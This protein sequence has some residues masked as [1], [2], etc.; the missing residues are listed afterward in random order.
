[1]K[2]KTWFYSIF[3]FA[4]GTGFLMLFSGCEKDEQVK[5]PDD[6]FLNALIEFGVDTDGDGNIST[7]EAEAIDTLDVSDSNI[8]DLTGIEAFVNLIDLQ[9]WINQLTSLDVSNNT[10]LHYLDCERN[11]LY[12]LNVSSNTALVGLFCGINNVT[13]LDLSNN[14]VLKYLDCGLNGLT[15]LDIFTNTVLES[16]LC[17]Y[18]TQLTT[19]DI[20]NNTALHTLGIR[21]MPSLYKVCVWEMPITTPLDVF[22]DGSPNFYFTTD[23]SK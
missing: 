7:D 20:S 3:I 1:M 14:T 21:G 19:L 11:Q 22:A 8:S 15:T 9:C 12:T 17:D 16:L 10:A 23:C 2:R 4:I 6:N 13:S 18:C 5:I